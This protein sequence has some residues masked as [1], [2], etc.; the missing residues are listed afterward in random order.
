MRTSNLFIIKVTMKLSKNE[1]IKKIALENK[2][3]INVVNNIFNSL[4]KK[5]EY[6]LLHKE[7]VKLLNYGTL[8]VVKQK[9]QVR[10]VPRTNKKIIVK[11]KN[12]IKFSVAKKYKE[13]SKKIKD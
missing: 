10:N 1:L 3:N 6:S 4:E 11:A 8:K 7:P 12:V 9:E 13:L 2:V 5:I